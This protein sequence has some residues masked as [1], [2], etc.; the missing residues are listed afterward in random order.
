MSALNPPLL[1]GVTLQLVGTA[2]QGPVGARGRDGLSAYEVWKMNGNPTGTV[3]DYLLSLK[4]T[5]GDNGRDIELQKSASHV[6]WRLVGDPDWIDLVPLIDIKGDIGA[7]GATGPVGPTGATGASFTVDDT[8]LLA[9]RGAHDSE[10]A[11][12]SYL[13]TDDGKL[14]IRQGVSGWSGGI[15]FGKGETGDPGPVGATGDPGPI[16][17]TGATGATG[18]NGSDAPSVHNLLTGLDADDHPQYATNSRGDLRWAA[19]GHIHSLADAATAGF[20]SN[21]QFTKLAGI[22]AGA[23]ANSPDATLL[24]RA[25]HTGTQTLSTLAASGASVGQVPQWSG[26]AWVPATPSATAGDF[27]IPTGLVEDGVTDNRAKIQTALNTGRPVYLPS[28]T[29]LGYKISAR[30]TIYHGQQI[31]G[32]E[33]R[34]KIIGSAGDWVFEITSGNCVIRDMLIDCTSGAGCGV[35]LMRTDLDNISR[36]FI[37][38][39]ESFGSTYFMLDINGANSIIYLSVENCVASLHRGPGVALTKAFAYLKMRHVTIDYVGSASRNHAAFRFENNQGAQLE[40]LDTTNGG[41]DGVAASD[42]FTFVNCIAVWMNNCMADTVPGR[43]FY[44]VTGNSY[45]YVN[46]CVA[47]LCG[48]HGFDIPIGTTANELLTFTGCVASGRVGLGVAPANANGFNYGAARC[49]FNNTLSTKNTGHG[50]ENLAGASTS[51]ISGGIFRS[52]GGRG[53]KGAASGSMLCTGVSILSNTAGNYDLG[54][55]TQFIQTSM[56]NAGGL[57]NVTGPAAA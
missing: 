14:Y 51:N 16:G 37:R 41:V 20:M 36:A 9:D 26:S 55:G 30:L 47:S 24:A 25:N 19:L 4:G 7:T 42:G 35:F 44:F 2:L 23:T 50:F 40:Y 56:S 53:I 45:F 12:F 10:P 13:A 54:A 48:K 1:P 31:F 57:L 15:P 3:E 34:T 17:P 32:D 18:A 43:G 38:N 6:Q 21:A 27:I 22:A 52:N 33:R 11:G 49:S 29:G 5:T 39:I 46:N 28:T 8:G